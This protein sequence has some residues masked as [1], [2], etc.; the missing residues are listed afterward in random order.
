MSKE[1]NAPGDIQKFE[2]VSRISDHNIEPVEWLLYPYIPLGFIT[3]I[4][5]DPGCG[6]SLF[7]FNL[8]ACVTNGQPMPNGFDPGLGPQNIIYQSR[9]DSYE[10][11]IRPKLESMNADM[12]RTFEIKDADSNLTIHDERVTNAIRE[13]N[14]KLVVFDTLSKYL[15]NEDDIMF[16]GKLQPQLKSLDHAARENNC[17]VVLISHMNKRE[18]SKSIY[19]GFGTISL[20]GYVRSSFAID[21]PNRNS[22]LRVLST[23]KSNL[24]PDDIVQ[25]YELDRNAK[26]R[27]LDDNTDENLPKPTENDYSPAAIAL[28]KIL[29]GHTV[30]S[31]DIWDK[32]YELGFKEHQVNAAKLEIGA[33]SEKIGNKWYMNMDT[34]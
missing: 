8:S 15:D 17:A 18:G 24:A 20:A 16:H 33:K 9:E 27:F 25:N 19:R 7:L 3:V 6:K 11:V 14:A 31:T 29:A 10:K 23:V 13:V 2:Y 1:Q 28:M 21:R 26:Y 34:D 4:L 30:L 5:G 12:N 22:G 32:M